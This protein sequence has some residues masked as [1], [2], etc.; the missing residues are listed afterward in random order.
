MPS[1]GQL[2]Y[3]TSFLWYYSRAVLCTY[4]FFFLEARHGASNSRSVRLASFD[5]NIG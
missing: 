4:Y 2:R 3:H 1:T 5:H